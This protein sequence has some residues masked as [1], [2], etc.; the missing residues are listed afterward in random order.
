M[1]PEALRSSYPTLANWSNYCY[2]RLINLWQNCQEKEMSNTFLY[3]KNSETLIIIF[4][5]ID[6]STILRF[7]QIRVWIRSWMDIRAASLPW[8]SKIFKTKSLL[9]FP[10][11]QE[12][13]IFCM[14]ALLVGVRLFFSFH[15]RYSHRHPDLS[16]E[17]QRSQAVTVW[18]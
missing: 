12:C 10:C 18:H 4:Y 7:I 9:S 15:I 2:R 1:Q 6:P 5:G 17:V 13:F 8:D 11:I 3:I 14:I 16:H